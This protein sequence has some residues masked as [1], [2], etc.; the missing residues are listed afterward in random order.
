MKLLF[1]EAV[2]DYSRYLYP[3]VVWAVPEAGETPADFFERGFLPGSPGLDR[4]Y[5]CRHL[6]VELARY[7][8]STENR[9]ILRKG[10]GIVAEL[11]ARSDFD[12]GNGRRAAWKQYADCRFGE[13]IMSLERLDRLMSAPVI[14]HLLVFREG[15]EG[16]ELG[17]VL[18]FLEEPRVAFYYYAF[19]DLTHLPRNLGMFMM[20]W[21]LGFFAGRGTRYVYLGTCYSERALYKAQ[22]AGLEFFNGNLWSNNQEE[23]KW[24]V[25]GEGK[26][27]VHLL[28]GGEYLERFQ[29]GGLGGLGQAAAARLSW[30]EGAIPDFSPLNDPG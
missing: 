20:T 25:R 30:V 8:P 12:Y 6:R 28:E 21:A 22:F 2:A 15:A 13:E 14:T 10:E 23:L 29:P 19:Y 11:V 1:S 17:T 24:L 5:L 27:G 26:T 3:Y 9:R 7:R 16:R 4:F 18:L